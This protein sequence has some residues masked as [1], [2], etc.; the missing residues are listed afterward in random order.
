MSLTEPSYGSRGHAGP[1]RKKIAWRYLR[2]VEELGTRGPCRALRLAKPDAWSSTIFGNE[3]DAG[4]FEGVRY[5]EHGILRH[6]DAS[7]GFRSLDGRN[8]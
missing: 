8:G 4:L 2:R 6:P 1:R 3:L 5:R 7:A